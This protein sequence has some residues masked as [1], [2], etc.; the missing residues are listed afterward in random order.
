MLTPHHRSIH[1]LRW[2]DP[3][4]LATLEES[5][6]IEENPAAFK[7]YKNAADLIADCLESDDTEIAKD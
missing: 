3:K 4:S 1:T 2:Q 5:K 6:S 7:T